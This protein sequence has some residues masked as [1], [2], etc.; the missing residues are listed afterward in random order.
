MSKK[1]LR[2]EFD[3]DEDI[4]QRISV[5]QDDFVSYRELERVRS[6]HNYTLAKLDE[7]TLKYS[8]ALTRIRELIENE[9]GS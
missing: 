6:N 9:N 1:I 8:E 2:I 3:S 5:G 4:V 7:L